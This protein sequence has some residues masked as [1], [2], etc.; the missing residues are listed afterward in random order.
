MPPARERASSSLAEGGGTDIAVPGPNPRF[1][2]FYIKEELQIRWWQARRDV[3]VHAS[4]NAVLCT[5][6]CVLH[7]SLPSTTLARM[8]LTSS[9]G[10]SSPLV[11]TRP[12][13]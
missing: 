9:I 8:I 1:D 11:L 13:L 12:I 4:L 7:S 3:E 5:A 2:S 10:R 6:S